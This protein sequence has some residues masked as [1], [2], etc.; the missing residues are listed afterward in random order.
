VSGEREGP[1]IRRILVALDASAHSLA[2]LE[3]AVEL[4]ARFRAELSGLY[5]E[6]VNILRLGEL[7]FV[8]EVGHFTA[9]RRELGEKEVQRQIRAQMVRARRI[10]EG[11]SKRARLRRSFQVT[12]GAV[13]AQVLAAASAAD[14]IVLGRSGW[15][16]MRPG[17]LGSTA[18][19]ILSGAPG[20]ALILEEGEQ[21]CPPIVVFYDGSPRSLDALAAATALAEGED[22]PLVVILQARDPEQAADL[23]AGVQAWLDP[24]SLNVHYETLAETTVARLVRILQAQGCGTLVLPARGAMLQ[25]DFMQ[26]LMD[27]VRAPVLLV[28]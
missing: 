15:S 1:T 9:T 28:R 24:R 26:A 8:Q 13:P 14:M 22:G 4:A 23:K 17:R 7:S 3:A 16:L 18:R 5:V 20:L 2:A 25:D 10:F 12:R 6:D 21:I 19:A 27:E 11:S